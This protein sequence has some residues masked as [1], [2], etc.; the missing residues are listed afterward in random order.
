[1]STDVSEMRAASI[2]KAEHPATQ[3]NYKKTVINLSS[4][5]LEDAAYSA[6][7]KGLNYAVSPAAH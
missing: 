4:V 5:P 3:A 6:F 7:C 2:T 1:M